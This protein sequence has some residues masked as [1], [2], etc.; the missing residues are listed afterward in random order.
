MTEDLEG[1]RETVHQFERI[2]AEALREKYAGYDPK[3]REFMLRDNLL[4]RWGLVT[5]LDR[6]TSAKR[7]PLDRLPR[8]MYD[9]LDLKLQLY[10]LLEVD[11]G[12]YN[13]LVYGRGY[14]A[15]RPFQTPHSHL[16]RLSLDQSFIGKSR[17]LWERVMNLIYLLETGEPLEHAKSKKTKFFKFVAGSARWRF[18]EVY[19]SELRRYDDELRTPEYH[20]SSVLRAELLGGPKIDTNEVLSLLNGVMNNL[21]ENL[22]SIVGGGKARTFSD[23]HLTSSGDIDPR[24]LQ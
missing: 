2:L 10:Y 5:F 6:Y 15:D 21:W 19:E 9:L 1:L 11:A 14:D 22:L 16:A 24:Y 4:N 12:L 3:I 18:L 7:Y 17:V 13:L 23:L 20:K 8:V